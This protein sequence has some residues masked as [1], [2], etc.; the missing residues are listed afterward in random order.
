LANT[1]KEV[2]EAILRAGGLSASKCGL[3]FDR[4][5]VGLLGDLRAFADATI[6][7]D[8][9]LKRPLSLIGFVH[10][11]DARPEPLLDLAEHWLRPEAAGLNALE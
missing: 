8:A 1:E 9:A 2:A 4:V 10:N 7:A 5:A 6:P 11:A 3:R